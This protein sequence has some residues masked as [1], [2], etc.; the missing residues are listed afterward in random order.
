[1]AIGNYL[2]TDD[3][4]ELLGVS[5]GRVRQFVTDGRLEVA[6]KVGHI[7]LFDRE[8]VEKLREIPRNPGRKKS[9]Q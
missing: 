6:E 1:M 8:K 2:T 9:D 3:A 5:P 4:A 7:N